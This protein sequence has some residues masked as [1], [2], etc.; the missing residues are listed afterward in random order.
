MNL[1]IDGNKITF[2]L[3]K[4]IYPFEIVR[5]SAKSFKDIFDCNIKPENDK[6]EVNLIFYN[7]L[8]KIKIVYEFMNYML[9]KIKSGE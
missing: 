1:K 2:Y 5:K 9:A 6:L 4:Y 3:N 8:D 7:D